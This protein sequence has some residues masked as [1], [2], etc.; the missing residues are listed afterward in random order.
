[1]STNNPHDRMESIYEHLWS[2]HHGELYSELDKSLKP[3]SSA[4]LYDIVAELGINARS[5]VLDVGCGRGNHSCELALRF[6]CRVIGLDPVASNLEMARRMASEEGVTKLVTFQ[7]GGIEAMPFEDATFDLIWC[8]DMLV[9]VREL[10][11]GLAECVRVLKPDSAMLVHTTF[12]TDL[13]EPREAACLYEPLS[14][15]P[16]NM[17]SAYM[18]EAF[19]DAGFQISSRDPIGGEWIEYLE[20]HEG[21]TLKMLLRVSRMMRASERFV[22]EFGQSAYDV[23]L[24]LY[25]WNIYLLLGKLSSSVYVLNK[26]D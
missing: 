6:G 18:E 22:A 15:V 24:A 4:M 16:E 26:T 13:M 12:A 9:H 5:T 10:K 14:V 1:M 17:S 20:E 25:V 3:R 19:Q 21:R 8:R 7:Q 23:A 2:A 11:Q